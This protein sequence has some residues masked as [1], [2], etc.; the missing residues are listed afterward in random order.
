M[1][2]IMYCNRCQKKLQRDSLKKEI[3]AHNVRRP[4]GRPSTVTDRVAAKSE[5]NRRY[6]EKKQQLRNKSTS[7]GLGDLNDTERGE[8][9]T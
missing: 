2:E 7:P 9:S 4:R 5:Y 3:E 8:V 6:Y 1:S